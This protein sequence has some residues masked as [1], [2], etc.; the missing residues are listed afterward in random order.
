MQDEP[1]ALGSFIQLRINPLV[2][3]MFSKG[4]INAAILGF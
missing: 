4:T 2:M 3:R 1:I